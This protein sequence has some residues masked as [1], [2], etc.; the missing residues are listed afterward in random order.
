MSLDA[1]NDNEEEEEEEEE[2]G[3]D[4]RG[5]RQQQADVEEE[6]EDDEEEEPEEHPQKKRQKTK[7]ERED[8]RK[9]KGLGEVLL[10]MDEYCPIIPD[11]VTD[12]Y[13]ARAGF[14]CDDVRVKRLLALAAQKFIADIASDAYQ[15]CK[16]RQQAVQGKEKKSTKKTVL[17]VDDLSGALAEHG[18]NVK[19]PE[20]F[21]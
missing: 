15:H 1:S 18:I 21:M 10:M 3:V 6:E 13:L 17:T 14:E 16:I 9:E 12:Y 2:E 5:E 11:A 4:E 19:K 20:Y 8:E 7:K